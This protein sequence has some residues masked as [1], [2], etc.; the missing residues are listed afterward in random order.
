MEL[1]G[2]ALIVGCIYR[3]P[4]S[5]EGNDEKLY[6][7]INKVNECRATYILVV[8]DCN[9]P[10]L[11]LGDDEIVILYQACSTRVTNLFLLK[12]ILMDRKLSLVL[13]I[14]LPTRK[15][16]TFIINGFLDKI[17]NE[18]K[19]C[20]LLSDFNN[21]GMVKDRCWTD[22]DNSRAGRRK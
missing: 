20:I 21:K 5:D 4:S 16:I 10:G 6:S 19:R 11:N 17:R 15:C 12:Y 2:N 14:N 1:N 13:S 7:L 18:E 22:E 8:G 3:S 9:Y